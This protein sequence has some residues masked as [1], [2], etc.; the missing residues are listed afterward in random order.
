MYVLFFY[1]EYQQLPVE[2]LDILT[3]GEMLCHFSSS[4][5]VPQPCMNFCFLH[6]LVPPARHLQFLIPILS[7]SVSTSCSH[8]LLCLPTCL[9]HPISCY[10]FLF[11]CLCSLI[12]SV[13]PNHPVLLAI[14]NCT[15]SLPLSLVSTS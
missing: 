10:R 15:I 7:K 1:F 3:D 6:S 2:G 8:H 13:C 9:T 11:G 14:I 5:E 12:H 4:S